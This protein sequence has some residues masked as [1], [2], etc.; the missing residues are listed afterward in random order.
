MMGFK[1]LTRRFGRSE[2]GASALEFAMLSP[3]FFV[4]MF[5]AYDMG[6]TMIRQVTLSASLDRVMREVRLTGTV[7]GQSDPDTQ[8]VANAVCRYS[9]LIPN[10]ETTIVVDVREIR[11]ANDFPAGNAPC[12]DRGQNDLRPATTQLPG[13]SNRQILVRVCAVA[14][15]I[16]GMAMVGY[17]GGFQQENADGDIIIRAATAYVQ[18]F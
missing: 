16:T 2:R 12:I 6:I 15:S 3:I 7:E 8:D 11:T 1:R 17:G 18:E 13:G 10:C 4:F 9:S 14:S 5:G